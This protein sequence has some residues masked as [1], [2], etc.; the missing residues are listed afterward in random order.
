MAKVC[1]IIIWFV[2]RKKIIICIIR[3][4]PRKIKTRFALAPIM[5]L[6]QF[7]YSSLNIG[8]KER[9][10]V[11]SPQVRVPRDFRM[12]LQENDLTG[13]DNHQTFRPCF[14][15]G[16]K[17]VGHAINDVWTRPRTFFCPQGGDARSIFQILVRV[18]LCDHITKLPSIL[19]V[20]FPNINSKKISNA[21]ILAD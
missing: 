2:A 17:L 19:G 21:S 12:H 16:A 8:F 20:S 15:F 14:K 4:K 11:L 7:L 5:S 3:V 13:L 6:S 18:V 1:Y 9:L 10:C